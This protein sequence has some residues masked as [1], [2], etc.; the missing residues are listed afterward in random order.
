MSPSEEGQENPRSHS[1]ANLF[2]TCIN[3]YSRFLL[4]LGEEDCQVVKLKQISVERVLDGYGRLKVWGEQNRATLSASNRVSLDDALRRDDA[5]KKNV[6]QVLN[7]LIHQIQAAVPIASQKFGDI[8]RSEAESTSNSDIDSDSEYSSNSSED[9]DALSEPLS[10]RQRPPKITVLV[11]HMQEQ[12]TLLYHIDILLRRPRLSGRYLKSTNEH[13]QASPMEMYDRA[14]IK[15]KQRLWI[16]SFNAENDTEERVQSEDLSAKS[17]RA[18]IYETWEDEPTVSQ[19]EMEAREKSREKEDSHSIISRLA[20]ANTRRREQLIYWERHPFSKNIEEI[21]S[22]TNEDLHVRLQ[23][24]DMERPKSLTSA[25]TKHSFSDAAKSAFDERKTVS[26]RPRTMYASSVVT[27]RQSARVPDV[28][29]AAF[30]ED[31]VECPFC[32]ATLDSA[33]MQSRMSWN[34]TAATASLTFLLTMPVLTA[35][36]LAAQDVAFIRRTVKAIATSQ[37]P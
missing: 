27:G 32:H 24:L 10:S 16:T 33:T 37:A 35:T 9:S 25:T 6:A 2:R 20:R 14:H 26:G 7:L 1:L 11:A 13:R 22:V 8:T 31:Q 18:Q 36:S 12:I 23:D 5:L 4:A 30:E 34:A 21:A 15:E 17:S 28:P 29:R 3:E 19:D